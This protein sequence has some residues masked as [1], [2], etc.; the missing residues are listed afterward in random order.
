MPKKHFRCLE[1]RYIYCNHWVWSP[2]TGW[3]YCP[4]KKKKKEKRVW[5]IAEMMPL[6]YKYPKG[7]I[8]VLRIKPNSS[9]NVSEVS[10]SIASQ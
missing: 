10:H 1:A 7:T 9:Q 4:K 3:S 2:E 8:R 5:D 6:S